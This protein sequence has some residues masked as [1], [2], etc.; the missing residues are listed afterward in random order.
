MKK[1]NPIERSQYID[2]QYREYLKSTFE[3]DKDSLRKL[4]VEQL[5]KEKLFKGPYVDM[6][7]PF[8][9]GHNLDYLI[10]KNVLCKSFHKL[11]GIDFKRPLYSHQEESIKLIKNGRSAVITTGT[12]SGKTECFL[13]PILNELLSDLEQGNNEVGVRAIFLYPMNALVNDQIN[14]IRSILRNCPDITFGFFTG[15][16]GESGSEKERIRIGK[17]NGIEISDNELVTREEIRENPPHLLFTNYSML[18]YL[19]I[20]PNDYSIFK[21]ERLKAW[22]YVVLDEA[23]TYYGSKGIEISLL[24]RRLTGLALERPQ[25]ILTSATLGNRENQ[26]MTL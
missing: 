5:E 4:F 6:S 1:L 2:K 16:T 10:E 11:D 21:P 19:L 24:L 22:K 17:E 23:H 9:R 14:R 18:E 26:R 20:R 15:E 7:F 13:Y 3:F 12:G 8:E 25:F